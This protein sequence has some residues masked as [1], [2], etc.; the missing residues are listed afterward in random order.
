MLA[1]REMIDFLASSSNVEA[2]EMV[3][4]RPYIVTFLW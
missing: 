1:Y 2:E 4:V 3:G